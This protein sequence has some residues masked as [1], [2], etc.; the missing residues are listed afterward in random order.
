[1]SA[2]RDPTSAPAIEWTEDRGILTARP[3]PH[4]TAVLARTPGGWWWSV[5][6]APE[7][8]A[9]GN[10]RVRRASRQGNVAGDQAEAERAAFAA[11]GQ[12]RP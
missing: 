11:F 5:S 3:A 2:H 12:G 10:V 8:D 4:V 1:M 7:K 6:W 9:D